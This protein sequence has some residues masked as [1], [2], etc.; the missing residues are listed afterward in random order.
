M[1]VIGCNAQSFYLKH[2]LIEYLEELKIEYIDVSG[3]GD[4]DIYDTSIKVVHEVL[5]DKKNKGI[6]LDE[7]GSIPF[8][9]AAKHKHIICAQMNDCHSAKMTREHNNTNIITLGSKI[10]GSDVAKEIVV[11]F[12]KGNYAAGRHQVRIDMLDRMC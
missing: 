4:E 12:V 7:Y 11:R 9:I 2:E 1:I 5:K 10:I 6:I 3:F 8:M